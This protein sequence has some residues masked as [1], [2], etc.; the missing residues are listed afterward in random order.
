MVDSWRSRGKESRLDSIAGYVLLFDERTGVVFTCAVNEPRDHLFYNDEFPTA[1]EMNAAVK[2]NRRRI[3]HNRKV[4]PFGAGP[5]AKEPD[6]FGFWIRKYPCLILRHPRM[7]HLCGYLGVPKSHRWVNAADS[8][9]ENVDV[10]GGLTYSGAYPER[11][12]EPPAL[13]GFYWVGFDCAHLNDLIPGIPGSQLPGDVYRD[14]NYVRAQLIRLA[15]QAD[16][17]VK[18]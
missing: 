7:G 4:S 12:S 16:K 3:P 5:W 15:A 14:I 10:H 9:L 6:N 13:Q 8:V 2:E 17:H 1:E 11:A 18:R